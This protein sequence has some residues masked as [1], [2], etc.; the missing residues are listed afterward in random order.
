VG[1]ANFLVEG[2]SC[3]GKTTVCKEL[4]RRGYHGIN[5][6]TELA[7]QGDPETGAPLDGHMHE[8]HIWRIETVKALIA[9]RDESVTF[10]CGGS[11]NF[12]AFIHLF[13][14]VFVLAVDVDT[15]I[16]RLDQRPDDEWGARPSERELIIRLH[17][18]G[19]DTPSGTLID[20]TQRL[21]CVVDDI[22]RQADAHRH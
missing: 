3:T 13:D 4:Q 15:L 9:N 10:F 2:G 11:R 8:H 6:D 18:T 12:P 14:D 7:Y 5:G 22:I 16:Q 20:S 21:A 1:R 17:R 19:H